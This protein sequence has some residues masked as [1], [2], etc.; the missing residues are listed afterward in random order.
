MPGHIDP[1]SPDIQQMMLTYNVNIHIK[2]VSLLSVSAV[3]LLRCNGVLDQFGVLLLSFAHTFMTQQ[4]RQYSMLIVVRG[5]AKFMDGVKLAFS[6]VV[7]Y[8]TGE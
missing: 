2:P 7:E 1:N 6:K 5:T 3:V 8:F 4:P